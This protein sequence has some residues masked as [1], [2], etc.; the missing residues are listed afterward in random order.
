M[1]DTPANRLLELHFRARPGELRSVRTRVREALGRAGMEEAC[2]ADVVMAV[3]EASQ[4]VI[5]HA[6]AGDPDGSI[7]LRIDHTSSE[8]VIS[9]IDYAPEVDP[10]AVRGR[11]LEDLR[12]G[13]LGT[14]FIRSS[15]DEVEFEVPPPG[16]GNLLRMVKRLGPKRR[17]GS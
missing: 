7:E 15:M 12:P 10:E 4:N 6:Y 1:S 9:L 17:E 2:I 5:R 11:N 13:G 14:H 3:D 8:L 16:C